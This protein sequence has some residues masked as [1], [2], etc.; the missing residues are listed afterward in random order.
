[1]AK[2]EKGTR[3]Y[4]YSG[5]CWAWGVVEHITTINAKTKYLFPA[6]FKSGE[7]VYEIRSEFNGHYYGD[8]HRSDI[9]KVA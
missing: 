6:S 7:R 8:L 5:I 9:T 4:F 3:V 2:I 1:M